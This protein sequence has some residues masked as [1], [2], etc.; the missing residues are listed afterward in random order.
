MRTLELMRQM[1]IA[2]YMQRQRTQ[3]GQE[4]KQVKD[5]SV[6]DFNYIPDQPVMR[7]EGKELIDEMIRFDISGI[8]THR[9]VIGSR[10]SGKTLILKFLEQTVPAHTD[11]DVAYVNCRHHNTS[12]KIFSH[13][14]QQRTAGAS[15][16]DLYERFLACYRN[17]T[18]VVLDEVDLMSPKDKNREI[19]YMLSRSEQPYM[20][21][22][23]SN[24][25]HVLKQL[26]AATRSSL[27]PVPL[28]FKNY[29]AEQIHQILRDRAARG[30]H[31][32]QE[33]NLARI[34][35]LTTRLTNADA[36][37]AIK[38]LKYTVTMPADNLDQCFEKARRDIVV[39]MV[40]DLSDAN[41]MILWA[42]ATSRSDLA[43]QIYQRYCR[44]SLD[45]QD[46][47]FSYVYF[48]ANLS[49][50]QSVGLL[51]LAATKVE[52]TYTNRVL[53]TFDAPI[54]ASLCKLRF[55]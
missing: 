31:H 19:L 41:L 11:L 20:V 9:A 25:P 51:A 28:H 40:S 7:D 44:F 22:M 23:L 12:F 21:I 46:K 30:L 4:S 52:R 16:A 34:A 8:P 45:Q 15:L 27:Q 39:D 54:V 17:K 18:V 35:A 38:T 50:L 32:W 29:N 6:F 33:E 53:L 49:Y 14:L 13:L 10:G 26:D 43:K 42:V 3:L 24:S 1:D 55:G 37:V 36:R 2:T 5:F 47:P 48:Y